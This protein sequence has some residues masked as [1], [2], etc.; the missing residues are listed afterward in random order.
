MSYLHGCGVDLLSY[1][2]NKSNHW[3][4]RRISNEEIDIIIEDLDKEK[5]KKH[6]QQ[7]GANNQ[8]LKKLNF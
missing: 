1:D 5:L 6:L 7:W 3:Y 8:I 4:N 2:D